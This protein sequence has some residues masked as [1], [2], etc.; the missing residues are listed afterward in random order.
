MNHALI[1]YIMIKCVLFPFS[2][3]TMSARQ[4]E[5]QLVETIKKNCINLP[6]TFFL[7]TPWGRKSRNNWL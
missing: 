4:E 1:F 7:G 5:G 2:A 3:L 6:Y